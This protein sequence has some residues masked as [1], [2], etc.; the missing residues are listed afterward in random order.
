M[1][2]EER[3][4][5]NVAPSNYK[6]FLE[7]GYSVKVGDKIEISVYDLSNGSQRK[8][9]CRCDNCPI[10][11]NISYMTYLSNTKNLT[12]NY[13]CNKCS[14]IRAKQTNIER[15]GVDNPMKVKEFKDKLV[16]TNIE[17]YGVD[18]PMKSDEIKV[19]V[20]NT[21]I[22]R[23]GV[24]S[25]LQNKEFFDKMQNTNIERY[26]VKNVFC[27]N[28]IKEKIKRTTIDKYGVEHNSQSDIIKE[29]KKETCLINYGVEHPMFSK[30][31]LEKFTNHS[32]EFQKDKFKDDKVYDF[33][34]KELGF[35]TLFHKVCD[36]S[37]IIHN[38]TLSSRLNANICL[39]TECYPISDN[40]SI[41][42]IEIKNFV[43]SFNI[44][45]FKDKTIL[46]GKELDIYIPSHNLAIE[47]NGL[48]WHSEL[49]KDID[50]HLNKSLKCQE[51]GLHLM[52]IWEDEWVLKQEI[53]KSIISNRL[54]KI[55]NKIFARK[56][57][58]KEVT[59][60]KI[61]RKFLD[62]NHIQGFTNSTTKLGLYFNDELVSLM[63]FGSRNIGN[64]TEFELIRFCN[65]LNTNV[66][67]ASSKLFKHFV[68]NYIY[69]TIISYSDFR[70]FDGKMYETL[71]FE[72]I[73]LSVPEYY[74]IK[75]SMRFLRYNFMK[76]KLIK[77]GY[78]SNKTEV[79]IMNER[80][81]NKIWGCG[82]VKWKFNK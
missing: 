8:I 68:N 7:K 78:D 64:K 49:Y 10:E 4:E 38:K 57:I 50:Y 70:L 12:I 16:E 28:E 51:K 25:A 81:Y 72:K 65:I 46:E 76:H 77:E 56:C 11:K 2:I 52:H 69:D 24:K 37:F 18:N 54:D 1:I 59:D 40:S 63:T 32:I 22:E 73:H 20:E 14:N 62:T 82:Q 36:R 53:V 34:D 75:D 6:N 42:E 71:G 9:L 29:K 33:I 30:E 45:T 48:Y 35:F 66:I 55:E 3:I 19:K 44:E 23:Y 21:N 67:G 80:G 17:R 15:Y 27:N 39:C 5:V 58:I 31:I 61:I 43:E 74:W 41:K 60:T 47:F 13:Y 79:E 26:G